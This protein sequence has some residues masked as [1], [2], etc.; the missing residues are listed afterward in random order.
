MFSNSTTQS[1]YFYNFL[2][3]LVCF[4]KNDSSAS[5]FE[6]NLSSFT[7]VKVK[8]KQQNVFISYKFLSNKVFPFFRSIGFLHSNNIFFNIY[9]NKQNKA[10]TFRIINF[11]KFV[12]NLED[13][14]TVYVVLIKYYRCKILPTYINL[15]MKFDLE[16]YYQMLCCYI[17]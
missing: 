5:R 4:M 15:N 7:D 12:V 8:T 11:T 9:I 17:Q 3:H 2:F 1:T 16:K 13:Q 6:K 10:K 14:C